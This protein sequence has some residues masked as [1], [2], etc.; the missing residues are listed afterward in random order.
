M[1]YNKPVASEIQKRFVEKTEFDFL[2]ATVQINNEKVIMNNDDI[3]INSDS[4][5]C[6]NFSDEISSHQYININHSKNY[7]YQIDNGMRLGVFLSECGWLDDSRKVLSITLR[8]IQQLDK[9]H[10]K[11]I[12]ELNCLQKLLHV[13]ALF[14]CYKEANVTSAQALC[15]IEQLCNF[16]ETSNSDIVDLGCA[17][18]KNNNSKKPN[19]IPDSLLANFYHELS[20]LHFYR[21]EYDLSYKWSAKALEYL[22]HDTPLK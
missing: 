16:N 2:E 3:E 5:I 21:S 10:K 7:M 9:T 18:E 11:L 13:Q 12:L 15:V 17:I 20:V 1:N 6:S 4:E 22:K 19:C 8:L 14:C